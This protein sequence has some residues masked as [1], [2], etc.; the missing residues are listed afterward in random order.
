MIT[1]E[2]WVSPIVWSND[3]KD[4]FTSLHSTI[5]KFHNKCFPVQ[6]IDLGY[7]TKKPWLTQKLKDM[8]KITNKLLY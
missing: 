3:P 1:N 2:D 6:K 8:I 5:C 4:A 7:K